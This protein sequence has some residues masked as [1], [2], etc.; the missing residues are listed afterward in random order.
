MLQKELGRSPVNWFL[1]AEKILKRGEDEIGRDPENKFK[2]MSRCKLISCKL[3]SW[4]KLIVG[5]IHDSQLLKGKS[6]LGISYRTRE[7]IRSQDKNL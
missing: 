6:Y 1:D 5:E 7:S 3:I 4:C 2:Q